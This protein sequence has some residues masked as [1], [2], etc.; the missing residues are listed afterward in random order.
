[1]TEKS[2]YPFDNL[3]EDDKKILDKAVFNYLAG[4]YAKMEKY[5]S[6]KK[7]ATKTS[8][9]LKSDKGTLKISSLLLIKDN[10]TSSPI[11]PEN[12]KKTLSGKLDNPLNFISEEIAEQMK[13]ISKSL[14]S[15]TLYDKVLKKLEEEN[16]IHN[17]QGEEE[18]RKFFP[19]KPGRKSSDEI[20]DHG[21]KRSIYLVDEEIEQLKVTLKKPESI[22][23]MYYQL[24][25]QNGLLYKIA[26]YYITG[27]FY[28]AQTDKSQLV[29]L[30]N[31][32]FEVMD[33]KFTEKDIAGMPDFVSRITNMDDKEI[34]SISDNLADKFTKEKEIFYKI[35]PLFGFFKL[36]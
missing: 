25:K 4:Y 7:Y 27:F 30:L 20:E 18:F 35:V 13:G 6:P 34:E 22:D 36:N 17:L 9:L 10:P 15:K 29:Q 14:N 12:L 28:I 23:Y 32:G 31:M 19:N 5:P 8:K 24:N 3:T 11:K 33:D 21:G 1:M 2:E 26:K 16:I